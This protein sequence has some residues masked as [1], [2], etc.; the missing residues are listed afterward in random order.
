[1]GRYGDAAVMAAN[2]CQNNLEF[3]PKD[4]W[5]IAVKKVFPS[6]QSAQVKGCPRCTFLALC[7]SGAVRGVLKGNYSRSKKNKEY[8]LSALDMLRHEPHLAHTES[9]LW[10]RITYGKEIVPNHQMEVVISIW[11]AGLIRA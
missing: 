9:L 5:I 6:S 7:G 1:M 3:S 4:A 11:N 10:H 8:A 2:F